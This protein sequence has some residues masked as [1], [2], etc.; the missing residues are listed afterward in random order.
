MSAHTFSRLAPHLEIVELDR[1]HTLHQVVGPIK[2]VHFPTTA[3]IS[4][5]VDT[6]TGACAEVALIGSEGG[7]GLMAALSGVRGNFRAVVDTSG[8]AYR[9][10]V[11]AMRA[12]LKTDTESH[13]VIMRYLTARTIQIAINAVCNAHHSVEQR[14][15]RALLMRL[16]RARGDPIHVTQAL[17][18]EI[19]GTRRTGVTKVASDLRRAGAIA[20][21]RG[22]LVVVDRAMLQRRACGCELAIKAQTDGLVAVD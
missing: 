18:A 21:C 9:L 13:R 16:D 4:A 6:A 12:A 10:K 14:L 22:R 2:H 11:A 15:C 3:V 5:F 17:L 7:V 1:G 19:L 8:K 20:Y